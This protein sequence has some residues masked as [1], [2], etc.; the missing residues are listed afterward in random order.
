MPLPNSLS[1][2]PPIPTPSEGTKNTTSSTPK[3]DEKA[4]D[5]SPPAPIPSTDPDRRFSS[6]SPT[7]L[8]PTSTTPPPNLTAEALLALTSQPLSH[9]AAWSSAPTPRARFLP[10]ATEVIYTCSYGG[11]VYPQTARQIARAKC[12]ISRRKNREN[13]K[14]IEAKEEHLAQ[15]RE[16]ERWFKPAKK[17]EYLDE[18]GVKP[19]AIFEKKKWHRY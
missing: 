16:R 7:T 11:E 8:I 13:F 9:G 10:Q 14:R 5:K 17:I 18:E 19:W 2:R 4:D 12:W 6:I 3:L 1:Q 15:Q